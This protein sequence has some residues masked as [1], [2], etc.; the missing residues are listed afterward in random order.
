MKKSGSSLYQ[1]LFLQLPGAVCITEHKDM[2]IHQTNP[3]FELLTGYN[4]EELLESR[5][6]LPDIIYK[7]DLKKITQ[8]L[9]HLRDNQH[10]AEELRLITKNRAIKIVEIAVVDF[11]NKRKKSYLWTFRDISA[12]KEFEQ[13]LREKIARERQ[14]VAQTAKG[15]IRN[16]K[17]LEKLH[18]GPAVFRELWKCKDEETLMQKAVNVMVLKQGLGYDS[19]TVLLR[20]GQFLQVKASNRSHALQRFH[21]EKQHKFAQVYRGEKEILSE[22]TGEYTLPIVSPEGIEGVMQVIF[23][24]TERL[25]L[26]DNNPVRQA[27]WDF[28]QG[29]AQLLGLL[30]FYLRAGISKPVAFHENL[31]LCANE[32]NKKIEEQEEVILIVLELDNFFEL[33]LDLAVDSSLIIKTA[34]EMIE[35]YK[36]TGSSLTQIGD[37]RFL[38]IVTDSFQKFINSEAEQFKRKLRQT[39]LTVEDQ[40][41]KPTFSFGISGNDSKSEKDGVTILKEALQCLRASQSKG[42]NTI[43]IWNEKVE[44]IRKR[45][46]T[47]LQ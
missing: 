33:V 42:G 37:A 45:V 46:T 14:K 11:G 15:V 36:P 16:Q 27:H 6:T 22:N 34:G 26:E 30:L 23:M 41:V 35:T 13:Q 47:R 28:L 17:L 20:E 10:L 43:H 3:A 12:H 24:E 40:T 32:L 4:E 31:K 7:K 25:L 38:L 18:R 39:P 44:E 2:I 21:I 8:R 19:V 9:G 5:K 1:N 29:V